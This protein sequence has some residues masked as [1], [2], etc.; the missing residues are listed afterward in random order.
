MPHAALFVVQPC[1]V[2]GTPSLRLVSMPHAAL[3]VVQPGSVVSKKG[4]QSV[5]MPHAALWV[6]QPQAQQAIPVQVRFQCRTR[7]CGWCSRELDRIVENDKKFQYRTRLCGWCSIMVGT[8]RG[9]AHGFNTARGFVGGAA[10]RGTMSASR[11]WGFQYR[12]RLCGWCSPKRMLA[13][14]TPGV[15]IPHAALWVVQRPYMLMFNF[16]GKFQYRTRLCGWCSLVA[17]S[18]CPP[19]EKKSFWKVSG[20]LRVLTENM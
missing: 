19:R 15:S 10:S 3:W 9:A 1:M 7:L 5:S 11:P 4:A 16:V 17:R 18:S 12:T 6:V 13:F 20:N 14:R 2:G 8:G